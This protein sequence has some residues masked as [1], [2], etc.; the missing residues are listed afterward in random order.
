MQEIRDKPDADKDRFA[1]WTREILKWH[2]GLPSLLEEMRDP[3][4]TLH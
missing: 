4:R 2:L 1:E 3:G